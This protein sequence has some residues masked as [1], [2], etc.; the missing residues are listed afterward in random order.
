VT[1]ARW[2]ESVA[3]VFAAGALTAALVFVGRL[4]LVH[5]HVPPSGRLA[6]LVSAGVVAYLPLVRALSPGVLEEIRAV[7]RQR[8][9]ERS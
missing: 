4:G 2:L 3:G 8:T 6:T 9:T 1:T 5:L 7:R